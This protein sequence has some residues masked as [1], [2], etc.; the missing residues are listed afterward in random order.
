MVCR[1]SLTSANIEVS[2]FKGGEVK[3]TGSPATSKRGAPEFPSHVPTGKSASPP[4]LAQDVNRLNPQLDSFG[5]H[6][7][8]MAF[9]VAALIAEGETEIRG[10]ESAAVS[11]PEF[12]ELLDSLI[13]S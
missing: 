7:I 3:F 1:P 4:A 12:Y 9:S 8:A 10:S 11:F 13:E 2:I 5:D 6:R